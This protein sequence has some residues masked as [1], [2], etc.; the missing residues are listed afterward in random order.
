MPQLASYPYITFEHGSFARYTLEVRLPALLRE[1]AHQEIFEQNIR[2]QLLLA[3]ENPRAI[4]VRSLALSQEEQPLWRLFFE[5]YAGK[6]LVE[7]PFLQAEL[8]FYRWLLEVT[9][10]AENGIDPFAFKK[11]RELAGLTETFAGLLAQLQMVDCRKAIY[12]ALA[13]NKADLS[14]LHRQQDDLQLLRDDSE[15]LLK[16]LQPERRLHLLLDNAGMELFS[17][18]LLAHQVL[19]ENKAREV[20]LYPKQLPVFVSDTTASDIYLTL[21]YLEQSAEPALRDFSRAIRVWMHSGRL[22]ITILPFWNCPQSFTTLPPEVSAH[23]SADDVFLSKGDANYRRFF[24]DRKVP[25][26][27]R[28]GAGITN[29]QFALRTLKSELVTGLDA[30]TASELSSSYPDWMTSGKFA[31]VQHLGR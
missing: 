31:V 26:G 27:Y 25:V 30:L 8:Y 23:W 7:V 24:E 12:I 21:E 20:I 6:S 13:G 3:A 5:R 1:V 19:V 4:A 15:E 9:R 14:L 11:A 16:A 17:D 18:L 22:K 29:Y 2:Q 10:F 28:G